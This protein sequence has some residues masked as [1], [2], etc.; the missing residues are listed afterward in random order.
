MLAVEIRH[1]Q[2]GGC[3]SLALLLVESLAALLSNT[4]LQALGE[5]VICALIADPPFS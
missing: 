4:L 3:D 5:Q 2:V 1:G